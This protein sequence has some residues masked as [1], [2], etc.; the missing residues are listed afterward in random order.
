MTSNRKKFCQVCASASINA[1]NVKGLRNLW[2][3]DLSQSSLFQFLICENCGFVWNADYGEFSFTPKS[4]DNY[5]PISDSDQEEKILALKIRQAFFSL[6]KSL[7]P[8]LNIIEVGSGRRLGMLK[9]LSSLFPD[10]SFFAVDP[11]LNGQ[12][13]FVSPSR[14]ISLLKNLFDIPSAGESFNV[15]I[16]RNSLEYFPPSELKKVFNTFFQ[17]EGLLVSELTSIDIARQGYCHAYSECLNFYRPSHISRIMSECNI[18]SMPL[19]SSLMHGADRMLSITRILS[20]ADSSKTFL[21]DSVYD[22]IPSLQKHSLKG[23]P[24]TVMYAAGGRNIMAILNHFDGIVDAV[25]DSDPRRKS[26]TLPFSLCFVER[27]SIPSSAN[28]VLLNSSFLASARKVFPDNLIF[29]L[30]SS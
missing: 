4:Y 15:L 21:Y 8:V 1:I 12:Q 17:N 26:S 5:T 23:N 7:T 30:T 9:E 3:D 11:I 22:L 13:F 18:K 27:D 2:S 29:V 24:L 14:S 20:P 28:I 19:E 25:F 10:S 6:E 16:F